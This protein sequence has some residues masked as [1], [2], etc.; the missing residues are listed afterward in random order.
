M[1]NKKKTATIAGVGV[2]VVALL[3]VGFYFMN[4]SD[5]NLDPKTQ[6]EKPKIAAHAL[7]YTTNG[8]VSLYDLKDGKFMGDFDL[9]TL[10]KKTEEV[11][12]VSI[13]KP[14]TL[15]APKP[16]PSPSIETYKDFI[17][18]PIS[19]KKG[20]NAWRIQ[21]SLTPNR[22]TS[23]MLKLVMEVNNRSSLHPIYPGEKITFLKEK[24]PNQ[25]V[26]KKQVEPNNPVVE[27]KSNVVVK[28]T[29]KVINSNPKYLYFNDIEGKALYAYSDFDKEVYTITE[30]QGKIEV[31]EILQNA[32]FVL[33]DDMLVTKDRLLFTEKGTNKLQIVDI[34]DAKKVEMVE[35]EGDPT[36]LSVQGDSLFYT[37]GKRL[38]KLS[39]SNGERTSVLLG[40]ESLNLI[41]LE[42]KLYILNGY[43]KQTTNSLLMKVNPSDLNVD[44]LLELKTDESA[45]LSKG[46]TDEL[47]V[48]RVTK[49]KD[50]TGKV[51]KENRITPINLKTLTMEKSEWSMP[52][53]R[54]SLGYESYLYMLQD[55][56]LNVYAINDA[57][58]GQSIEVKGEHFTILP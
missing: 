6:L 3:S 38:G 56:K 44:D 22:N 24:D 2:A 12:E 16:N 1:S 48:G 17:K 53:V 27:E 7:S 32:Q 30:A 26:E 29:V 50:L 9:K 47:Y 31:K 15:P 51:M 4:Q 45:I 21:S 19:I 5:N 57:K 40:D 28:K 34:K 10:S 20:Q 42:D 18:V 39:L 46:E 43:G 11:V 54:D 14:T 13:P 41:S 23:T 25:L 49:E 55:G 35:L 36:H 8:V 58:P 52:F 37:F 33:A